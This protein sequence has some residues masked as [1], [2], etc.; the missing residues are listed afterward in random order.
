M[1]RLPFDLGELLDRLRRELRGGDTDE[2]VGASG[3]QL[4]DVVI[5]LGSVVS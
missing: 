5:D 3:F 4:D 2:D 1:Q